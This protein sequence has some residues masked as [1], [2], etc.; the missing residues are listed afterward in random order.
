MAHIVGRQDSMRTALERVKAQVSTA[1]AA[2][3][4]RGPDASAETG[5]RRDV[6]DCV[7]GGGIE[8]A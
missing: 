3:R 6:F 7:I 1:W 5:P 2:G 4:L 8:A